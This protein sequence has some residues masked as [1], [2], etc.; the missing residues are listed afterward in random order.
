MMKDGAS[1]LCKYPWGFDPTFHRYKLGRPQKIKKPQNVFVC[2]VSDL[3]GEW[4][5]DEWIQEVFYAC[6]KAPQHRYLFLTK[7]PYRYARLYEQGYLPSEHWYGITLDH[8]P[9]DNNDETEW[10]IYPPIEKCFVSIEPLT[11]DVVNRHFPVADWYIIGA[12]TG[13]RKNKVIP[14]RKWVEAIIEECHRE[15]D[16]PV[17]L[18]SSLTEI[19]G[20]PLIQEYP[21]GTEKNTGGINGSN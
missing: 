17:F 2:S 11:G 21:W 10:T 6:K 20:E 5:P 9:D 1:R 7:N 19:W 12:E 4:V 13:N 3:F 8:V 14:K 18:K 15:Q 16:V